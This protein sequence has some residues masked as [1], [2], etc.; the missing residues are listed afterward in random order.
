[1]I[2]PRHMATRLGI[3]APTASP[4]VALSRDLDSEMWWFV[5]AGDLPPSDRLPVFALLAKS[6][7]SDSKNVRNGDGIGGTTFK[8]HLG[9]QIAGSATASD[10]AT[11][12]FWKWIGTVFSGFVGFAIAP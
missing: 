9:Q 1:M 4:G 11:G 10:L 6:R 12:A 8:G 3:A 5:V 7:M 2:R